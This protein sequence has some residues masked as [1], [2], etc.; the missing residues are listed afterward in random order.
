[1]I[2]YDYL[3]QHFTAVRVYKYVRDF[4]FKIKRGLHGRLDAG[5]TSCPFSPENHGA[6]VCKSHQT[7]PVEINHVRIMETKGAHFP[8][9]KARCVCVWDSTKE[10]IYVLCSKSQG[11]CE[12]NILMEKSRRKQICV[13]ACVCVKKNQ[14]IYLRYATY[15]CTHERTCNKTSITTAANVNST[16]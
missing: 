7:Q 4:F 11:V 10:N 1:M 8:T 13:P 2:S 6:R 14:R 12:S 15:K 5:T 3:L 16:R 9:A